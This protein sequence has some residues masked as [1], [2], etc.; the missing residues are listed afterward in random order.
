MT[1]PVLLKRAFD[2]ASDLF[3]DRRTHRAADERHVHG[4]G[5][6]GRRF[7]TLPLALMIASGIPELALA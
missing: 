3:A 6:H 4:A 1:R 2:E 5:E 7:P